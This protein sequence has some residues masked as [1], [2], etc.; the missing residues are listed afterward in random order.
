MQAGGGLQVSD[1]AAEVA[2]GGLDQR[3]EGLLVEEREAVRWEE[4]GRETSAVS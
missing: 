3:A 1:G 4:G 2:V